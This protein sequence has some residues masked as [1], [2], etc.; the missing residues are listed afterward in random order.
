MDIITYALTKKIAAAAVAG[1]ESMW[2]EGL[3]LYIKPKEGDVLTIEFP[4][5]KDGISIVNVS[6]N[7]DNRHLIC[8]MSDSNIIDAGELPVYIPQKGVDYY[9]DE[10]KEEI[11]Q[12]VLSS[13]D[14]DIVYADEGLPAVGDSS[15][16]YVYNTAFYRWQD[17][18]QSYVQLASGAS[19]D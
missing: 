4:T 2:V 15:V 17:S 6:I 7:Q 16:L 12:D 9:T 19:I 3:T 5:P 10:D 8:T 14:T 11:V 13:I 1:I 18:T